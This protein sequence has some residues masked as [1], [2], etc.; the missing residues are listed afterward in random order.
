[1]FHWTN[2]VDTNKASWRIAK[3]I[4][5]EDDSALLVNVFLVQVSYCIYIY[6]YI[7]QLNNSRIKFLLIYVWNMSTVCLLCMVGLWTFFSCYVFSSSFR[8]VL[9][10]LYTRWHRYTQH[11]QQ[12]VFCFYLPHSILNRCL[13][14]FGW[15]RYGMHTL[16]WG[17]FCVP[18]M[19]GFPV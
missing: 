10:M 15:M 6:K 4:T 19:D 14:L 12:H 1:M 7:K 9:S 13:I 3:F 5:K 18:A 8:L 2:G 17:S 16:D 11:V